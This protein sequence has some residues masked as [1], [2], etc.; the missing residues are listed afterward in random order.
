MPAA[1][2]S[3]MLRARASV[4]TCD[5]EAHTKERVAQPI[6]FALS[7]VDI[8]ATRVISD[9]WFLDLNEIGALMI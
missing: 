5:D 7:T 9:G 1:I 2:L 4:L 8:I 6:V 3:N